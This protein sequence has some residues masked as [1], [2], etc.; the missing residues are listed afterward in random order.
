MTALRRK[1]QKG[2][3][4][5]KLGGRCWGR[6]FWSPR[7]LWGNEDEVVK[8]PEKLWTIRPDDSLVDQKVAQKNNTVTES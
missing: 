4:T 5:W 1:A 3:A 7:S 6:D 2:S 8:Y